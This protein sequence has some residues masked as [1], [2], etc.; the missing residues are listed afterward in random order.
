ML[1]STCRSVFCLIDD[2]ELFQYENST[3]KRESSGVLIHG[4]VFFN[5]LL[6][7]EGEQES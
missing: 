6:E 2:W 5:A 1:D 4:K 3:M 7:R